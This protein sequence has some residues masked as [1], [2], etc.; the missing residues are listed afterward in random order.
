MEPDELLL[1]L[2]DKDTKNAFAA[3]KDLEKLSEKSD[4]LYPH[5][6]EFAGMI[7]SDKYVLRVRG[8]CLLCKQARWD[9]DNFINRNLAK[10]LTI[11]SDEKPTAVRQALAALEEV[12]VYKPE[13]H[14]T[15]RKAL[16]SM[17]YLKY[18]DSMYPLIE[19]DIKKLLDM[20]DKK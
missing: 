11:L 7:K 19:K 12:V 13:L 2:T 14:C 10:L 6:Q 9:K 16:L 17:D 1:T 15:L 3:L 5:I 18:S 4:I 20:M 8:F